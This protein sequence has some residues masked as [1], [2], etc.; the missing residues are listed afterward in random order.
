M[1]VSSDIGKGFI[2]VCAR[3]VFKLKLKAHSGFHDLFLTYLVH[4]PCFWNIIFMRSAQGQKTM[5]AA[6]FEQ[7][8]IHQH[9][10]LRQDSQS[11]IHLRRESQSY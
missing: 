8:M 1:P 3:M 5:Y 11:H 9:V 7:T 4:T 6:K 10:L 2:L